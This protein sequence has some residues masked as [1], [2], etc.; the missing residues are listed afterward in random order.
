MKKIENFNLKTEKQKL[1]EI[2]KERQ[3]NLSDSYVQEASQKIQEKILS[4][5]IYKNAEKIFVYISTPK[6][7]STIEIINQ[8]FNDGKKI[9]VP[10]CVNKKMFAV[11]IF[12]SNMKNLIPGHFGILEPA[13]FSD[14]LTAKD[15]DLIIVP[16][17]S[18][19]LDG[20]RLGH[21]GGYYDKF[22]AELKINSEFGIKKICLCFSEMLCEKIPMD[23]NDIYISVVTE[24]NS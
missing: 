21:G 13:D 1:R 11:R 10:K 4:S 24:I 5:E 20:K 17:L 15:F 2:I 19:S 3:K 9:Y 14:S 23:E 6:E 12:N 22:L 7:P 8:A 18:A 16:C